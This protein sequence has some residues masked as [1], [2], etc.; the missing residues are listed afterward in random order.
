[1]ET[2][3]LKPPDETE[4]GL[5]D[6]RQMP[7]KRNIELEMAPAAWAWEPEPLRQTDKEE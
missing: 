5:E 3:L 6:R 7:D 2:E 4:G 1:M